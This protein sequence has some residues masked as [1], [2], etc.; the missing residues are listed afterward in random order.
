MHGRNAMQFWIDFRNKRAE[1]QLLGELPGLEL[2]NRSSLNLR[3]ISLRIIERFLSGFGDEIP[4]R[5]PF[6]LHVALKVGAP[7]AENVNR[8]HR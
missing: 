5:F 1:M 2:S 4:D 7:A 6:L 8:F 3:G